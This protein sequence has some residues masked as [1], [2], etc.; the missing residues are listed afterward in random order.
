MMGTFAFSMADNLDFFDFL[1]NRVVSGGALSSAD[2]AVDWLIED[3]PVISGAAERAP[4][5]LRSGTLRMLMPP[6]IQ[7]AGAFLAQPPL[8]SRHAQYS[9]I[10]PAILLKLRI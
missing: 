3:T 9:N 1:A 2:H 10:K 5:P 8:T 7:N 6:G 4:S